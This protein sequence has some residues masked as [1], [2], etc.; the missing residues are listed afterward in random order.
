MNKD[1][2]MKTLILLILIVCLS[3]AQDLDKMMTKSSGQLEQQ[4]ITDGGW[5]KKTVTF[6][7][8]SIIEVST[9]TA[10][11]GRSDSLFNT[12]P[13]PTVIKHV[14]NPKFVKTTEQLNEIN[15]DVKDLDKRLDSL[16]INLFKVTFMLN[17]QLKLNDKQS[18]NMSFSKI[19]DIIVGSIITIMAA[20][21]GLKSKF[22]SK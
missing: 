3:S 8:G 16:E 5:M 12:K 2:T 9:T 7:N 13:V 17:N 15:K 11:S 19:I 18:E 10:T 20:Y 4:G 14:Y 22:K 21:L 1:I 6:E